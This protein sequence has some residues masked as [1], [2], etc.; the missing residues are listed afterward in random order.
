MRIRE[1]FYLSIV[2][3]SALFFSCTKKGPEIQQ[4]ESHEMTFTSTTNYQNPY[5]DV[6]FWVAFIHSNYQLME[7]Q[8]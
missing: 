6:D 8:C 2:V 1:N 3:L 5:T 7:L 4:W